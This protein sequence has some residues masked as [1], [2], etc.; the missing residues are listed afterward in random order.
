M[1]INQIKINGFL[2]IDLL[3]MEL[4]QQVNMHPTAVVKG[5]IAQPEASLFLQQAT[6]EKLLVI[7][8]NDSEGTGHT[9]FSGFKRPVLYNCERRFHCCASGDRAQFPL[10]RPQGD[11]RISRWGHDL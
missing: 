3:E 2:F 5:H 8:A 10:R 6:A 11:P 4:E 7:T 1:T 9:L